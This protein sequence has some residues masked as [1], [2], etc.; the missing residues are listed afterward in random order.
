MKLDEAKKVLEDHGYLLEYYDDN[1]KPWT[2]DF[3]VKRIQSFCHDYYEAYPSEF[4][5]GDVNYGELDY[6]TS[7][8][9]ILMDLCMQG[10]NVV[11]DIADMVVDN[12]RKNLIKGGAKKRPSR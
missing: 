7:E 11:A 4:L 8:F 10:D 12:Y 5:D 2:K 1:S 6:Y 3:I 9:P